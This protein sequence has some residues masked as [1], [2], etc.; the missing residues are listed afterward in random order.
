MYDDHVEFISLG[1]LIS[2]LSMEAILMGVSQSRNPNLAAVFYRMYLVESY[3]TGIRKI[4]R[5]YD[6]HKEMPIF[7]TAE[8]AFTTTL[9]NMNESMNREE[10]NRLRAKVNTPSVED[11]KA[12]IYQYAKEKGR[13]TRKEIEESLGLKTTKAFRLIKEMCEE[14][15]LQQQMSGKF[16]WYSPRT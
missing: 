6:G 2:G 11:E 12:S 15:V 13:I 9:P 14:G 10:V 16:T 1:G 7:R 5:L 8:G 4:Q 3:G